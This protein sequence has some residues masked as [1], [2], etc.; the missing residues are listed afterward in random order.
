MKTSI[1]TDRAHMKKTVKK[2]CKQ[3]S[4]NRFNNLGKMGTCYQTEPTRN[5]KPEEPPAKRRHW[6][7]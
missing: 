3:F 4:D 6:I 2:E 7:H 1:C 5:R